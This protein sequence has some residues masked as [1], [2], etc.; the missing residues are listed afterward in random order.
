VRTSKVVAQTVSESQTQRAIL[1]YLAAKHILSFRMQTGSS[2]RS[3][4]GKTRAIHFGVPGMADILAF[5]LTRQT[6]PQSGGWCVTCEAIQPTWIECKAPGGRQSDLQKSF[7]A[8]VEAEGHSYIL[9]FS[10]D[11][12]EGL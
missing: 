5:P 9:A 6:L 11:D 1:D 12:L 8:Q 4:G 3:Y 7:Q 2:V 10:L